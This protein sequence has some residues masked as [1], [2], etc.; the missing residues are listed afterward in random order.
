MQRG[1]LLVVRS[2]DDMWGRE[3]GDPTGTRGPCRVFGVG[4]NFPL[5]SGP[6]EPGTPLILLSVHDTTVTV[7]H[8]GVKGWIERTWVKQA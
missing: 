3:V 4:R 2:P 7:L 6:L 8:E 1:D 5:H